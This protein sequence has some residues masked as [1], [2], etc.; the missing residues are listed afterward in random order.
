MKLLIVESPNKIKTIKKILDK[1][2]PGEFIVKATKGHILNLPQHEL[3]VDVNLKEKQLYVKWIIEKGKKKTI[4]EIK[5]LATKAKEVF[6]ATDDD[7]EGER[8]ASDIVNKC[9]IKNYKRVV[10]LEITEKEILKKLFQARKINYNIVNAAI[11]RR[12]ID[13][14]I[15]YPVSTIIRE[16]FYKENKG[17]M[18]KGVGRV[19]SP[20]LHIL[21]DLEKKIESFVVEEHKKVK[22]KYIQN[23]MEFDVSSSIA[24][25]PAQKK[26]LDEYLLV[27]N[28]NPH[29]VSFYKQKTEDR[30][31]PKPLT[32]STLQYGAWYLYGYKPKETMKL[33]QQLFEKGLITYHRTD[34]VRMSDEAILELMDF[35]YNKYG[36]EFVVSQPRYY[37][38][39]DEAQNAHEA[40]R[41]TYFNEN[42]TP[43][44]IKETEN[45]SDD[46]KKLYEFIWYRTII[47]QMKPSIYDVSVVE[48]NAGGNEFKAQSNYRIFDGW[49]KIRGDIIKT[50]IKGDEEEWRDKQVKLPEFE[51]GKELHP[52]DILT[53]DYIPHRP[54]RF[55]VG[56]FIT[57]L[58]NHNIAR[59]STLDNI[60]ES[61][62]KKGYLMIQK[63]TLFPKTL[64][65]AVDGW[66]NKNI[67]WLID[68]ELAKKFEDE[69]DEIE[70]GKSDYKDLIFAYM[71]LI[72][73]L[74]RKFKI[75][76]IQMQEQPTSAQIELIKKIANE[77][78]IELNDAVLKNKR[79]AQTFINTHLDKISLGKCPICNK[80]SVLKKDN[81][82]YCNNKNCDFV[83]F[84]YEK[85]F[86]I[87]KIKHNNE[88]I[89]LFYQNL[90]K[91]KKIFMPYLINKEGKN[92]SAFVKIDKKDKYYNLVF[93][94][95]SKKTDKDLNLIDELYKKSN[96]DVEKIKL[97]KEVNALKEERRLL[98]D[99]Q[100]KDGLTRAFNRGALN[101]DIEKFK[102]L[103]MDIEMDIAFVDADHFKHVNDTYGHKMGDEVLKN[104]VNVIFQKIREY[105]I[106]G[107]LYR[108]GGEEFLIIARS[109][110]N[111]KNF[112]E[113]IRETLQNFKYKYNNIEFSVTV[114]IGYVKKHS[115][116]EIEKG[117]ELADKGVYESKENGRNRITFMQ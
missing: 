53:Y 64:G 47:T 108:Y 24:F 111:F 43:E 19:I 23:G 16:S 94:F 48:I 31:P 10:F 50:S 8:I 58:S 91:N 80:G 15:G 113:S 98:K 5:S 95:K 36:D 77:K 28:T 57:Y 60:I 104:I 33:A 21:I 81:R 3:G 114:S 9:N 14:I 88:F 97:E 35:I 12:V 105:N 11:A 69:L 42:Y 4:D 25:T 34:S 18:P 103:P 41:P 39:S 56:R 117:V 49:E 109:N 100:S 106:S 86:D 83:L 63:G 79:L 112:L 46:L 71:D 32:T 82:L 89:D 20:S 102:K 59:P 54:R 75:S 110:D 70:K 62:E 93:D 30:N 96:I 99:K 37:K 40:I 38:N 6:I 27:L 51:I 85:F 76:S 29:I 44:K 72:K 107:R 84:N 116:K 65:V 2:F 78:N 67:E 115:S 13:R 61:L 52:M 90:F 92:F 26:E 1:H 55:G 68:I 17:M 101:E 74:E 73:E 66:L 7:R 45:I 22:I 87:F